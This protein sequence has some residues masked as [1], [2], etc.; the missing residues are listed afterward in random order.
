MQGCQGCRRETTLTPPPPPE[1]QMFSHTVGCQYSNRPPHSPPPESCTMAFGVCCTGAARCQTMGALSFCAKFLALVVVLV[2]ILIGLIS[3]HEEPMGVVFR[4]IFQAQGMGKPPTEPVPE[5]LKP[6]PRPEGEIL[7]DLP[8]GAKMPANGIG[9]CCRPT[10][11]DPESVRRTVLWYLLQGGRHIDTAA[12]YLNQKWVGLGIKDAIA[13]GVPREEIF[14]TSK[15]F[16]SY[17]GYNESIAR[18]H[19]MVEELGVDYIDLVLLHVPVK[20]PLHHFV[21]PRLP[22]YRVVSDAADLTLPDTNFGLQP[23]VSEC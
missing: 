9:M 12:V 15:V 7:F 3:T 22:Y 13:R 20:V 21:L 19:S 10:A 6:M 2:A 5:D 16:S 8:G 1:P 11:Y 14:L 4:A 23:T 17:F 18:A